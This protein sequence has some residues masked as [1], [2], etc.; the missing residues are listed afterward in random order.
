MALPLLSVL[1]SGFFFEKS[2]LKMLNF[3]HLTD[4]ANKSI[5]VDT[6]PY[7]GYSVQHWTLNQSSAIDIK[8]VLNIMA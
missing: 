4:C 7:D 6:L 1:T 2:N 5:I 3:L 8:L